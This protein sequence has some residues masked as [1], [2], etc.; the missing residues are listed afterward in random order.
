MQSLRDEAMMIKPGQ[1]P[2]TEEYLACLHGLI[3]ELEKSMTAIGDNALH[4]YE[5]SVASQ[6]SLCGRL[7]QLK[8][9]SEKE[10]QEA[11]GF[12]E[13]GLASRIASA[14]SNLLTLNRRYA[15]L[16]RHQNETM[17]LLK[18]FVRSYTGTN[19]PPAGMRADFRT[20][21]CHL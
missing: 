13:A 2:V 20:W 9:R 14:R 17:Q 11:G 19:Y 16:L 10:Q 1:Q 5:E 18:A 15:A 12:A 4:T 3:G 21:S 7:A 8:V 6:V